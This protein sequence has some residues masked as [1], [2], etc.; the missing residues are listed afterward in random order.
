[1]ARQR[2]RPASN[3][4]G[5]HNKKLS[6]PQDEFLRDY[7]FMLQASGRAADWDVIQSAATRLLYY[8]TGDSEISVS[9]R[10]T[11][12]WITRNSEFLKPLCEKPLSAKRLGAHIVEDVQLHFA[13]FDRCKKKWKVKDEDILN[14][15]ECGF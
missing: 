15:D 14:F 7:I 8:E 4:R 10:W 9:S 1:M 3:T 2:G 13:D 11:K 6:A 5:G 12:G